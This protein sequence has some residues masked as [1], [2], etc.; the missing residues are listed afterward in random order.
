LT[1]GTA[2]F[3][4]V[5]FPFQ[6]CVLFILLRTVPCIQ[7]C[8]PTRTA[9]KRKPRSLSVSLVLWM[10]IGGE[11]RLASGSRNCSMQRSSSLLRSRL[12]IGPLDARQQRPESFSYLVHSRRLRVQR[13][14]TGVWK[15]KK[16]R[17]RKRV[18]NWKLLQP[19]PI[20]LASPLDTPPPHPVCSCRVSVL[21]EYSWRLLCS[22]PHSYLRYCSYEVE[23]RHARRE[24]RGLVEIPW[25]RAG[26]PAHSGDPCPLYRIA[27]QHPSRTGPC[28]H[29]VW[30]ASP[31]RPSYLP[32]RTR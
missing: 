27:R 16:K 19:T 15:K 31:L 10:D 18:K 13:E 26:S 11:G 14:G 32:T 28:M 17:K 8:V 5:P 21:Y 23:L 6:P 30:T 2:Q 9:H 3:I 25:S 12:G 1:A 7:V 4:I 24:D 22:Q 29:G 20:A